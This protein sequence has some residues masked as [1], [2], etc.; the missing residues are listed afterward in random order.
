MSEIRSFVTKA[1]KAI[2]ERGSALLAT[3][4]VIAGLSLL[5]LA[6]VAVSETEGAISVNERNHTQTVALA[7]A[8]ARTVVQWFQDPTWALARGLMPAN[9]AALKTTRTVD[10]Y[11]GKY[12]PVLSDLLCDR[13]YKPNPSNRFYGTE[14]S[15]DVFINGVNAPSYLATLNTKLFTNDTAGE[16]SEIR[17]YAPPVIGGTL[18]ADGA[19]KQFWVGGT[20]YGVATIWVRAEKFNDDGRAVATA[21]VKMVVSEFPVPGPSGVL[22]SGG[23][24]DTKGNFHVRWGKV[25]AQ[26]TLNLSKNS[27]TVPWFDAYD[28][29]HFEHGYDSSTAWTASTSYRS[30]AVVRPS[31]ARITANPA[32]KF[33]EYVSTTALAS[34]GATEPAA[35]GA[36][37]WPTTAGATIVDGGVTWKER[38]Q[39]GFPND[40]SLYDGHNWLYQVVEQS[41]EDPWFEVRSRADISGAGNANPQPDPYAAVS[42]S[43][44]GRDS[45]WFQYQTFSQRTKYKEVIF[46]KFDYDYW[47]NVAVA[48]NGQ[49]GVHFL[50]YAGG[51]YTDGVYTKDV[52]SWMTYEPG[53]YFFDTKNGLNPQNG[54]PGVLAPDIAVNGGSAN[55]QGYFYFNAGFGTKGLGSATGHYQQPGEPYRDVGYAK[56]NEATGTS[57]A[58]GD[59]F[60]DAAG[61]RVYEN[62]ANEEWDYQDLSWSNTGGTSGG[63][64][65][66]TFDVY[67]KQKTV[68][69][70]SGS[71]FTTWFVVPYYPGCHPG[72]NAT[73]GSDALACSEPHE[74]YLNLKYL[75]TS[76]A[77]SS[78]TAGWYDPTTAGRPKLT[79]DGTR[80]GTPVT[81]TSTSSQANCTSNAYDRDGALQD[82][83]VAVDGVLYIEGDFDSTGNAEYY[84][85]VIAAQ[86]VD[87]KGTPT[88]YFDEALKKG[89]WPPPGISLPRVFVTSIQTDQ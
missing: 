21:T 84:G 74:A 64:K 83:T 24:L 57:G 43:P 13:P 32:L 40:T 2:H 68:Q 42:D 88:V 59:W 44:T 10:G 5:G 6:F 46:P 80:Y 53:F 69:P 19:G 15:P 72:D 50:S 45:H 51:N 54:G 70:E 20:R 71:S 1:Q 47:K 58:Q 8:G 22:E 30:E 63:T 89:A 4:M 35:S 78:I 17:I 34:S 28:H 86:Y 61:N 36:G 60:R 14:D 75:D 27:S 18:V 9:A 7:E 67:V 33:H 29:A 76:N 65:N 12:K 56:V 11:V 48:G 25:T 38:P 37:S 81:C 87:P 23:A 82:I 79:S 77:T 41:Y 39:T 85:S 49:K 31:A 62:A 3:L 66:G 16:I 52:R 55:A 73:L 26:D